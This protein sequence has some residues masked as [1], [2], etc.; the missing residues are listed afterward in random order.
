MDPTNAAALISGVAT[1]GETVSGVMGSLSQS[2]AAKAEAESIRESAKFEERQFKKR[3]AEVL[4][5]Q[6]AIGA[7]S[8]VDISSGSPLAIM[9]DTAR[10]A[11]LES[12]S[13]RRSGKIR[14]E[15]KL[16]E[17]R[18]AKAQI[19]G[20]IFGGLAKGGSIL[21]TWLKG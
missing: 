15:S 11:A 2:K 16:F 8:G 21:G 19:P 9:L 18:L 20:Q 7:A 4:S 17:G 13:I 1:I 3:A 12:L 10:E 14:S 6:R 5:K